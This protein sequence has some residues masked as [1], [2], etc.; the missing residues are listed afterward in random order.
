MPE[1]VSSK[2]WE[3]AQ[4]S[5]RAYWQSF[6]KETLLKEEAERHEKKAKILEEEW[7][8]FVNLNKNFKILQIGCGPEDVINYIS[9]GKRYAIDP[10]ADFYKEK[11]NLNYD[12][13]SF[14]NGRAEKLPFKD[15]YFDIVILANVLDHVEQPEKVLSEIKRVLKEKG[16][17]HFENLFY[18]KNFVRIAKIYGIIKKSLTGNI[19]NIHH[20]FMFRLKDLKNLLSKDFSIIYD[21]IG[22]DIGSY[23]T[24]EEMKKIKKKEKKLTIKI[25]AIFGLYGTINY[26][27]ICRK[28]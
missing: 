15:N 9:V 3:I 2:R 24:L 28:K 23:D 14:L 17:F 19:F 16:I 26:T 8:R 13:F 27:A 25:P 10:L 11:F 22:R 6:T 1:K 18:Q 7:K 5:E 12:S 21:E 4:D 20:P